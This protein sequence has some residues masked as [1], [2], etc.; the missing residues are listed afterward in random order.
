VRDDDSLE[1]ADAFALLA[2][3][4]RVRI[5]EALGDAWSEEWPGVLPYSTLMERVGV[6]DSGR[7]H[8]HLSRLEDRFVVRHDGGYKLDFTGLTV[9]RAMHARTFTET[10]QRGPYDAG[11]ACHA[12][13]GDLVARYDRDMF[14]VECP[15]CDDQFCQTP[16]PPQAVADRSKDELLAAADSL[17]RN[18]LRLMQDGICP[19]CASG[20]T[21]DVL[22]VTASELDP[23]SEQRFHVRYT[24]GCCGGRLWQPV[25]MHALLDER[26]VAVLTSAGVNVDATPYW[27]FAFAVTDKHT[28]VLD[29]DPWRFAV[30]VHADEAAHRVTLSPNLTVES[31]YE[32]TGSEEQ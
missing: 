3:E 1:P 26:F 25:G 31:L 10:R 24:C 15:D 23:S 22:E 30:T 17:T 9:Y 20:V 4:T 21:R 2:D 11:C 19:W 13:G 28:A 8:Y 32:R 5:L 16:I 7:F 12:C 29:R 6:E 14:V 27:E 18:Y